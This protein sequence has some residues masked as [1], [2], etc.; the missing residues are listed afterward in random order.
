MTIWWAIATLTTVGYGDVY[1]VTPLG[2][3]FA[4]VIAIA[5]IGMVALPAG[6]FA[7]AFSDELRER[8]NA[9][10]KARNEALEEE[11]ETGEVAP[12]GDA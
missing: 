11:I 10:L 12:K 3:F 6:V 1:P 4:S 8:E 2:R 9:K 5:G 7:S